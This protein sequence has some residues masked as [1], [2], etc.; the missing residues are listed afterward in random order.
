MFTVAETKE[1]IRD[2]SKDLGVNMKDKIHLRCH[3]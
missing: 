3:T 1:I 2:E